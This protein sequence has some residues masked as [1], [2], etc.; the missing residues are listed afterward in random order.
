MDTFT[1]LTAAA[2][3]IVSVSLRNR[4]KAMTPTMLANL[5]NAIAIATGNRKRF[6]DLLQIIEHEHNQSA[7]ALAIPPWE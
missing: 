1:E 5:T 3:I 7:T 6:K 4:R 2:R